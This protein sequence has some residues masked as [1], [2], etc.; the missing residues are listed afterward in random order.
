MIELPAV[1]TPRGNYLPATTWEGLVHVS[2]QV[3]RDRNEVTVEGCVRRGDDLA[4][5]R[6][7]AELAAL[8]CLSVLDREAGGLD[9]VARVLMVRGYVRSEPDFDQHPQVINAASDLIVQVLGD[10]G[11]HA[12][13]ALGV[14]SIPTGGLVE[15]EMTAA[16]T[17][18]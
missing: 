6:Q 7:A 18:R 1:P 3:S 12:R 16:L 8:R 2:G 13:I 4:L 11:R 14:A 17:N 10:R 15:I 9:R 5:A